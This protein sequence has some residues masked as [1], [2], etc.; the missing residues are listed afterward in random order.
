MLTSHITSACE[1]SRTRLGHLYSCGS[2][3]HVSC[4]ATQSVSQFLATEI[5]SA[6]DPLIGRYLLCIGV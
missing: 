1:M 4:E 6:S 2:A 5:R 3:L